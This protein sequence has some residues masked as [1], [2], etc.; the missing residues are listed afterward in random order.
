MFYIEVY[1][2]ITAYFI[3]LK[4]VETKRELKVT[5]APTEVIKKLNLG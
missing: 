2:G 1:L 5:K 4:L 3:H